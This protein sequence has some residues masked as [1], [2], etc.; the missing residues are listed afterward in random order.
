MS[1]GRKVILCIVCALLASA[2]PRPTLAHAASL[3]RASALLGAPLQA[4]SGASL[5]VVSDL[6]IDTARNRIGFVGVGSG[7]GKSAARAVP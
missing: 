2:A 3:I 6:L 1:V 7:S 4:R 5:G